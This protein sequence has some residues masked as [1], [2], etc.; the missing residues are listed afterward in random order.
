MLRGLPFLSLAFAIALVCGCSGGSATDGGSG[1]GG[2]DAGADCPNGP[3]ALLDLDIHAAMG[4]VP[5][6]T[7]VLVSW[8][9]GAEPPFALDDP[10]TWGGLSDGNVVC[11]VDPNAPPPTNLSSLVCHLWTSGVTHVQVKAMG[12]KSYEGMLKP[13]YS[14]ACKGPIPTQVSITLAALP[15]GGAP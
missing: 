10:K 15:D 5:A 6:D 7:R 14:M 12:Y 8:S 3:V 9:A 2:G 4:P 1:G 13:K 11:D